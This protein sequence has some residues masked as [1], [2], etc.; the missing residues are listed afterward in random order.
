MSDKDYNW[1]SLL[2]KLDVFIFH[3]F[4]EFQGIAAE[5]YPG[6]IYSNVKTPTQNRPLCR[7]VSQIPISVHQLSKTLEQQILPYLPSKFNPLENSSPYHSLK[8]E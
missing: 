8:N 2:G 5:Y 1:F 7:I 4:V 3:N 6:Y